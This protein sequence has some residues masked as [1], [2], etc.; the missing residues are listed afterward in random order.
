[1]QYI[2]E[3]ILDPR[4]FKGLNFYISIWFW[5]YKRHQFCQTIQFC[6][7]MNK[8]RWFY[9]LVYNFMLNL[10]KPQKY[11]GKSPSLEN[12]NYSDKIYLTDMLWDYHPHSSSRI[13]SSCLFPDA[14]ASWIYLHLFPLFLVLIILSL[15]W[16]FLLLLVSL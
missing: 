9:C 7:Q 5:Q 16:L 4:K 15:L 14:L 2:S 12:C 8:Y 10:G 13:S 6:N 11:F 3:L 1:M